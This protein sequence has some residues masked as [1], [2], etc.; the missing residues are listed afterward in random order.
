MSQDCLFDVDLF[1]LTWYLLRHLRRKF[2]FIVTEYPSVTG[3]ID[4]I[5]FELSV[6]S[7]QLSFYPCPSRA[8]RSFSSSTYFFVKKGCVSAKLDFALWI[9]WHVLC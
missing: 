7:Q 6:I 2:V 1:D 3:M 5:N 4:L 8:A 9:C